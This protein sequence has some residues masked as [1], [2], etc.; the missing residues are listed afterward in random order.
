MTAGIQLMILVVVVDR[1]FCLEQSGTHKRP[2]EKMKTRDRK[3]AEK[4]AEMNYTSTSK[5]K[6]CTKNSWKEGY[7][8]AC[9]AQCRVTNDAAYAAASR[10]VYPS[11]AV[12]LP[13][14]AGSDTAVHKRGFVP[15]TVFADRAGVWRYTYARLQL[16]N[17]P[18]I[19][20]KMSP[21]P[22]HLLGIDTASGPKQAC[23]P[24][25]MTSTAPFLK[26]VTPPMARAR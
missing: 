19:P 10:P 7:R 23:D 5:Q 21:W 24:L 1:P 2:A 22:P 13:F 16:A 18:H 14:S 3:R 17:K 9:A 8:K 6:P 25:E 4:G 20:A 26:I 11:V 12:E 15:S